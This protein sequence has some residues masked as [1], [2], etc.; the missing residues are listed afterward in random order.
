MIKS[1]APGR[2]QGF[3]LKQFYVGHDRCGMKVG[4]D[5]I[6]LGSWVNPGPALRILDIG[7]GSGLLALMMAQ[8]S[9]PQSNI[10]GIDVDPQAISQARENARNGPWPDK[11]S[12]RRVALQ[13]LT[14][15]PEYDLIISNPPYF[16][17]QHSMDPAR[18]AARLTTD[19][20]HHILATVTAQ[21]LA[22]NGR[23]CCILPQQAVAAFVT[24]AENAGLHLH[25]RMEVRT[26]TDK[27][28]S[29]V[30]LELAL[31]AC[32]QVKNET[33]VIQQQAGHYT[34]A[35][36]KLCQAFYVNF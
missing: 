4:T 34:Q 28:V 35:Y 2:A 23:F 22:D 36:Q 21:L 8:S 16:P 32:S 20:S 6:M 3:Q 29:R 7:T 33:I 1:P 17:H 5:S 25:R 9:A 27:S 31:T 14:R 18:Q 11:I 26:Q 30:M 12:F 19:L 10:L 15:K 13:E 24:E